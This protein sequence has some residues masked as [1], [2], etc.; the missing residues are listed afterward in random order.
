MILAFL[1]FRHSKLKPIQIL[2]FDIQ[3]NICTNVLV[4]MQLL[5][6]YGLVD[7]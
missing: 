7:W 3:Q 1:L 2:F 4:I 6:M 5:R